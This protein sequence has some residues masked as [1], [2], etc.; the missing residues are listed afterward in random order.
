MRTMT[1][2][3]TMGTLGAIFLLVAGCSSSSSVHNLDQPNDGVDVPAGT[4][5][6]VAG[7]SIPAGATTSYTVSDDFG[8][9]MDIAV[10]GAEFGCDPTPADVAYTTGIGG[11]RGSGQVPVSDNYNL[12]ISCFN[13]IADCLPTVDSW[14]WEN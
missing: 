1:T 12:A 6:L 4:C 10:V 3:M 13:S 2:K 8:D 11:G 7:A 5:V 9:D 14:T